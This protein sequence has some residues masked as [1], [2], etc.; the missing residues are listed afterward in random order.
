M[1]K[2]S[3]IRALAARWARDS[4]VAEIGEPA[5]LAGDD[6]GAQVVVERQGA[7]KLGGVLE[8]LR[9]ELHTGAAERLR[10]RGRRVGED[11]HVGGHGFDQ[12][13]AEAFVLAQRDV[14]GRVA[15]VDGEI[16]VG[17][18]AGEDEALVEQPV[19]GHQRAD[20]SNNSA[21]PRRSGR[22]R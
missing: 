1:T 10:H 11:R 15:V 8:I 20:Q 4:S 9:R 6:R 13:R 18:R 3:F 16:L 7:G 17:D 21:A 19:L 14:D 12:R 2:A 5:A 22:R